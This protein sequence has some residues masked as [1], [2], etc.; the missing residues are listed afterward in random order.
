LTVGWEVY[1]LNRRGE[2]L[3]F[4]LSLVEEKRSLIRRAL[5]R[6][7][8]FRKAPLP[9][10]S[11]DEDGSSQVGNMFR[12]VELDLPPLQAGRYLLRLEM[13]MPYR[14]KV[15]SSRRVTVF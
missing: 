10:L 5:N 3:T 2:P 15:V 7:G 4:R 14:N 8:L 6:I 12:V 13:E 9:T 1:G 11:W